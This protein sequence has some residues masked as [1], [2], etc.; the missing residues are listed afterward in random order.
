MHLYFY[1]E[2]PDS[3]NPHTLLQFKD[4]H[5]MMEQMTL[6]NQQVYWSPHYMAHQR[7]IQV[8][9]FYRLFETNPRGKILKKKKKKS[10]GM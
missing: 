4:I 6:I 3:L 8:T 1:E 7:K 5:S 9:K 10:Q 2:I